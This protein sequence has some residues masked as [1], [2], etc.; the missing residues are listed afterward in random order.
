MV[1]L[2]ENG[3]V[4]HLDKDWN[5]WK[6][7]I[8]WSGVVDKCLFS[9]SKGDGN[10]LLVSIVLC[11]WGRKFSSSYDLSIK[12][13]LWSVCL[14][15]YHPT[16]VESYSRAKTLKSS[17][18]VCFFLT[19]VFHLKRFGLDLFL[20]TWCV[21]KSGYKWNWAVFSTAKQEGLN[22]PYIVSEYLVSTTDE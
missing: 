20:S 7:N 1:T 18:S 9:L 21:P 16:F 4:S 5:K 12:I 19:A 14:F 11:R 2:R 15:F 3:W 6:M 22:W 13:L 10:Y 8:C 17:V